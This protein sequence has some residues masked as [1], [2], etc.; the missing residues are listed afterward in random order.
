MKVAVAFVMRFRQTGRDAFVARMK[1]R[2]RLQ[3]DDALE[4]LRVERDIAGKMN[5]AHRGAAALFG[6][7][8][9]ARNRDNQKEEKS[10]HAGNTITTT[11]AAP[12]LDDARKDH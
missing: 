2:P 8:R 7:R 9:S 10:S 12:T 11:G 6:A 4:D 1:G 5:A 3:A